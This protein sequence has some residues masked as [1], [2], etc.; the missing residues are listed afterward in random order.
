MPHHL[1]ADGPKSSRG[2]EIS[3]RRRRRWDVEIAAI[4]LEQRGLVTLEQLRALGIEESTIANRVAAGRMHRIHGRVLAVGHVALTIEARMLAAALACGPQAVLSHRSAAALWGIR[5]DP[6][7][8]IDVTAPG[9]RGRSP[10]GIVAHRDG[11]L[12]SVDCTAFMGIP[13]TTVERT[14]LDLAAV[15]HIGELRGLLP[16]QRCCVSSISLS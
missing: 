15:V 7:K 8:T 14:L 1:S 4:A 10:E 11:A 12:R 9:R 13:C 2:L 16:R 6:C 5:A 3:A